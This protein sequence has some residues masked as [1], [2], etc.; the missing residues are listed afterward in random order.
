MSQFVT[1]VTKAKPVLKLLCLLFSLSIIYLSIVFL[2][3]VKEYNVLF[4]NVHG[5]V[6]GGIFNGRGSR[7]G[8]SSFSIAQRRESGADLLRFRFPSVL[9]SVSGLRERFSSTVVSWTF[10]IVEV[11]AISYCISEKE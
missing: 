6:V 5:L 3:D 1:L 10:L 8:G 7:V 9:C 11:E 4:L 2:N